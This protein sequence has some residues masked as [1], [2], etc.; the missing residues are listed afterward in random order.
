MYS[1]RTDIVPFIDEQVDIALSRFS[2]KEY[3]F[4][5]DGVFFAKRMF[6]VQVMNIFQ[7]LNDRMLDGEA[8]KISV[9][10]PPRAGKSYVTS[11]FCSWFLGKNPTLCVMRNTVTSALYRKFSYDVRNIIRSLKFK[12]TFPGV[13]L[14]PDKSNIDGWGL[15]TSK[16]GAYFGNGVGGN[17]I[18]FGANLAI[19]DDLYSGFL[20]A[21]SVTYTDSVFLWKQGSH[22]SRMEKN[23]PEIYIGTRWSKT[24][25]IGK[26]IEEKKVEKEITISALNEF[27]QSFCEDVKSTEE[28]LKIKDET[29]EM[30]WS[31][32]YMQEPIEAV[33]LLFPISELR[34]YDPKNL[35]S[36]SIEFRMMYIDPANKGGDFFASAHCNLVGTDI[37]VSDVFCNKEGSDANNIFHSE[38]IIKE[39]LHVVEYEGVFAWMETGKKLRTM[40][41]ELEDC[42]FRIISPTTNKQTRILVESTFIKNHFMF[43][44]DYETMPQYK[45]FMQL[46]VTYMRDQGGVH[47]AANDDPPDVLSGCS[48]Y[49]RRNFSHLW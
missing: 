37:L 47:K 38:H 28:Y 46:L 7:E 10:M 22:D 33:G 44:E 21:L 1:H 39:K 24:D 49:F 6:L 32:E 40:V 17:L 41:A 4:Y 15:T 43:R 9:S 11:L 19:T 27:D 16:Q 8:I 34:F 42:E 31:A 5:M 30:I 25:V 2:F 36:E 14:S 13:D 45:K 3:C 18:G 26:A 35:N 12:K 20:Q 29:D 48:A 23:C